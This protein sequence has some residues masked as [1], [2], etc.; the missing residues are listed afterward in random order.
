MKGDVVGRG[1]S[2]LQR[3]IVTEAAKRKRLYYADIC[4][5]FFG[6][7]LSELRSES[8]HPRMRYYVGEIENRVETTWEAGGTLGSPGTQRFDRDV[9]GVKRYRS[10]LTII[11]RACLRLGD[12]G[13]VQCL[14]GETSHWSAVEITNKGREFLNG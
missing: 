11:S 14:K 9:I 2:K 7:P 4:Y 12:R 13:L 10:V 6:W 5:H 3:F 1:L 8:W